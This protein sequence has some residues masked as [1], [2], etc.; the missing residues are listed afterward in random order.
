MGITQQFNNMGQPVSQMT[1]NTPAFQEEI[2]PPISLDTSGMDAGGM[3]MMSMLSSLMGAGMPQAQV[4]VDIGSQVSN[5]IKSSN[6][7]GNLGCQSFG[8]IQ[9]GSYY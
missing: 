4:P 9:K 8:A 6:T 3:D 1:Y 5:A 7:K 2:Q